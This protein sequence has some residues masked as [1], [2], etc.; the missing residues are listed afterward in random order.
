MLQIE[1]DLA[2]GNFL[3]IESLGHAAATYQR[4][5]QK[6]QDALRELGVKPV[7]I[8][9]GIMYFLHDDMER[10]A[11]RLNRKDLGDN[12]EGR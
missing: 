11:Q 1:Q 7:F 10:A 8:Q 2:N 3:D 12:E 6:L 9:N 4:S 5:P